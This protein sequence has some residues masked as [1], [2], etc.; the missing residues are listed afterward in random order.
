MEFFLNHGREFCRCPDISAAAGITDAMQ[1]TVST[2]ILDSGFHRAVFSGDGF[3]PAHPG[4]IH[5]ER[6]SFGNRLK[7]HI[8]RG[9]RFRHEAGDYRPGHKPAKLLVCPV[10]NVF[11]IRRHQGDVRVK[12]FVNIQYFRHRHPL[13]GISSGTAS[14]QPLTMLH[15][16]INIHRMI[17]K[18]LPVRRPR[19]PRKL[20]ILHH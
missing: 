18:N 7:E 8:K 6:L 4:G 5:C 3:Q 1:R 16:C 20:A 13:P 10:I 11:N 12:P 2:P 17:I 14:R 19:C 15:G 9:W